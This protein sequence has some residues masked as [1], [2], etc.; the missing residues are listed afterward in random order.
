MPAASPAP[1]LLLASKRV[2]IDPHVYGL[3]HQSASRLRFEDLIT[4]RLGAKITNGPLIADYIAVEISSTPVDDN[5]LDADAHVVRHDFFQLTASITST[6][7]VPFPG[8]N[9]RHSSAESDLPERDSTE[10]RSPTATPSKAPGAPSHHSTRLRTLPEVVDPTLADASSP[11]PHS[12][13]HADSSDQNE[14]SSARTPIRARTARNPESNVSDNEP[15]SLDSCPIPDCIVPTNRYAFQYEP[16][17]D[18]ALTFTKWAA[19]YALDASTDK[20]R[21]GKAYLYA[22]SGMMSNLAPEAIW[23]SSLH[24]AASRRPEFFEL[25]KQAAL[26][27]R[28]AALADDRVPLSENELYRHLG[29]AGDRYDDAIAAGTLRELKN[30]D[31][32]PLQST[33]LPG[34]PAGKKP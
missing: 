17:R 25:L 20:V 33:S 5:M 16:I 32:D 11:S 9:L 19:T 27:G 30:E 29:H 12:D 13:A 22:V 28:D 4:R 26:D 18:W 8:R 1:D 2:Y 14:E 10:V 31:R 21:F 34:K 3:P 7:L 24:S 15:P 23:D 6:S